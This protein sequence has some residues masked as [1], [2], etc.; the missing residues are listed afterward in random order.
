MRHLKSGRKLGRD[1]SHRLALMRNLAIALF[2]HERIHTTEAKAKELRK[3]ADRMVTLAKKGDLHARRRAA[4]VIQD[5]VALQKL[6]DSIA[7]RYTQRVGGYTRIIK[8]VP[9]K[10]DG[11]SMALIELVDNQIQVELKKKDKGKS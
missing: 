7:S 6:F 8:T 1:T 4:R 2:T 9:R 3:V 11:A 5:K 10:G